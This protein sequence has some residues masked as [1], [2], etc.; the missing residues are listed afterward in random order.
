MATSLILPSPLLATVLRRNFKVLLR[1]TRAVLL[2]ND[3]PTDSFITCSNYTQQARWISSL[4]LNEAAETRS[5]DH[6]IRI[7]CPV[8]GNVQVNVQGNVQGN[9]QVITA[10]SQGQSV[11]VAIWQ[12]SVGRSTAITTLYSVL[13]FRHEP[14]TPSRKLQVGWEYQ[15][16][17][18]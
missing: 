16:H 6:R 11:L 2:H 1:Y 5:Q 4:D 14:R 10:P 3:S 15:P 12:R 9:V 13:L 17:G 18:E 8:R 7:T